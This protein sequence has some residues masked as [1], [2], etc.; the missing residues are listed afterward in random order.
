MFEHKQL[1]GSIHRLVPASDGF[2]KGEVLECREGLKGDVESISRKQ[3]GVVG[4]MLVERCLPPE[5]MGDT[6]SYD[7][8]AQPWWVRVMNPPHM[9][10]VADY[11]EQL[12]GMHRQ[13]LDLAHNVAAIAGEGE[14]VLFTNGRY[15]V[16]RTRDSQELSAPTL[17][18][19]RKLYYT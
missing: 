14:V 2:I 3:Y 6:W 9:G 10:I 11:N 18:E 8:V 16:T 17:A 1:D 4:D 13:H 15:N 5:S 12:G 7:N 19:L